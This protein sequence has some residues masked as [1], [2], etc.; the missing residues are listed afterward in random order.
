MKEMNLPI[1]GIDDEEGVEP[2][3]S[4]SSRKNARNIFIPRATKH[5]MKRYAKQLTKWNV[6]T[7]F[8]SASVSP[9]PKAL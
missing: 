9:D 7:S 8:N 3:S 5:S 4:L 1:S 6:D 2:A